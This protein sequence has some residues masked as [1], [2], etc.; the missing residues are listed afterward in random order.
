MKVD[1]P[2]IDHK[3]EAGGVRVGVDPAD[4]GSVFDDIVRAGRRFA[5]DADIRGVLVEEMVAEGV[6]AVIGTTWQAP[7]GHVVMVGLGGVTVELL[8]DV[9]FALAPVSP[10]EARAMIESLRGYPLLA[11]YRG[12]EPL[13]VG[14]LADAVSRVSRLS[15]PPWAR[16][17]ASWT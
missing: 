11:G 5:P 12:A 2:G 15:R 4:A 9:A 13:D 10:S 8:E 1:A 16:S 17:C 7:F 14:A 6:E 3:T